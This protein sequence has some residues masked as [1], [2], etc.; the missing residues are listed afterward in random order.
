LYLHY[1]DVHGPYDRP[2][3]Y[4]DPLM[5]AVEADPNKKLMPL[6]QRQA[7]PKG[8]YLRKHPPGGDALYEKLQGYREYWV[9]GYEAGVREEDDYLKALFDE[10]RKM[11]LWEDTFIILTADHG[12]AFGENKSFGETRYWE[13]GGGLNQSQ[14][15]VPLIMRWPGVLPK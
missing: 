2:A 15:H 10:L 3:K 11:G 9:A 14:L 4:L 6:D 12:E 13:H 8:H 7:L 5:K 1:M